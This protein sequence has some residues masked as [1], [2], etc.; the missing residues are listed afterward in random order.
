MAHS[1][2]YVGPEFLTNPVQPIAA[3]KTG[4]P[5]V[6]TGSAVLGAGKIV[7]SANPI[8]ATT[9]TINGTTFT[10]VASGATGKQ[11]NIGVDLSTSISNLITKLQADVALNALAAYTKTDTN[12]ALTATMKVYGLA[13]N[14]TGATPFTLASTTATPTITAMTGNT[15][16]VR[17]SLDTAAHD[18]QASLGVDHKI[19]LDLGDD[20]QRKTIHLSVKGGA[21]GAVVTGVFQGGTTLTFNAVGD[22]VD[23]MFLNGKWQVLTN[24]SVTLA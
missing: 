17:L 23:M 18:I 1:P 14:S 12:T 6:V 16:D 20:F 22:F 9:T 24:V 21:G 2:K 10:W 3:G 5:E 19:N 13:Y 11:V 8:A 4:K 15:E 7:F